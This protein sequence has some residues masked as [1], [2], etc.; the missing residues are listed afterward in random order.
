MLI[1]PMSKPAA[2]IVPTCARPSPAAGRD[3]D[4]DA[5][6]V[7]RE[8][9]EIDELQLLRKRVRAIDRAV[10]ELEDVVHV[11]RGEQ[12][13]GKLHGHVVAVDVGVGH[14]AR[15]HERRGRDERRHA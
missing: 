11:P 8:R 3:G 14:G 5:E 9:A 4:G 2:R 10:V 15:V 6:A 1:V 7:R 12:R 13:L